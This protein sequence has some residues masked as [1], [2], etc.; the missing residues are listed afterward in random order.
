MML[1]KFLEVQENGLTKKK[2]KDKMGRDRRKKV[3][4]FGKKKNS[5]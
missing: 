5:Q 2:R 1:Q 3:K 4:F